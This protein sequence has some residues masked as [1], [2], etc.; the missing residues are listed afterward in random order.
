MTTLYN[1][2]WDSLK[3]TGKCNIAAHPALHKRIIHAVINKKYY[4]SVYKF[5][6]AESKKT[7]KLSYTRTKSQVKFVLTERLD[8][9]SLTTEDI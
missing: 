5:Q 3:R 4:D 9:P 8:L 6:L 7:S 2:I 1:D